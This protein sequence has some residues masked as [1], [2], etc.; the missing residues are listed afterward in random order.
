MFEGN[1]GITPQIDATSLVARR[2]IEGLGM[3][4]A[5]ERLDEA[6]RAVCAR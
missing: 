1:V 3:P 2:R 5:D 4:T 6:A